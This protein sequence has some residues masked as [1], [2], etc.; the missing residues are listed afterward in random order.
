MTISNEDFEKLNGFIDGELPAE[1]MLV[2]KNRIASDLELEQEMQTLLSLKASM[3]KLKPAVQQSANNETTS[4]RS[5][6][7]NN[8]VAA[9]LLA[10][11]IG[12]GALMLGPSFKNNS[13][14]PASLHVELS[15]KTYDINNKTSPVQVSNT[16]HNS[17]SIPDLT[18]S[19]LTL[20]DI[21]NAKMGEAEAIA[22]H[23]RGRRGCRLTFIAVNGFYKD[24][25]ILVPKH[26]NLLKEQWVNNGTQFYL[27]ASGMDEKRFA[28]IASY[29]RRQQEELRIA[30]R[31]TY[32]TA[33]PCVG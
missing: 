16:S 26:R 33:R 25:S 2:F 18:P 9:V 28:A 30:M 11:I 32:Q 7:K 1:E 4:S 20:A 5:I 22:M 23:Y 17:L 13:L 31:K 6:L 10:A 8:L 15:E 29:A 27:F 3:E 14:S 19:S 24:T 21:R 12:V